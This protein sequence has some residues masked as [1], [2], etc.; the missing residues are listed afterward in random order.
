[1]IKTKLKQ[2]GITTCNMIHLCDAKKLKKK[3]EKY[4]NILA[5]TKLELEENQ[6]FINNLGNEYKE[7]KLFFKTEK[8]LFYKL[9]IQKQLKKIIV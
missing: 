5:E 1:M 2:L 7:E 6:K 9:P 3:V 4:L 8:D